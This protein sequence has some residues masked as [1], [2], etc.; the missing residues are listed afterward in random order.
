[1]IGTKNLSKMIINNRFVLVLLIFIISYIFFEALYSQTMLY[2]VGGFFGALLDIIGIENDYATSFI[3]WAIFLI[4]MIVLSFKLKNKFLWY[5]TLI[6]IWCL[7]YLVDVLFYELLPDITSKLLSN[8]HFGLSTFI[9]SI[10]LSFVYNIK[11][12]K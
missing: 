11:I 3:I 8:L 2:L 9:K 7:L 1:M 10:I 12:K 4:C 5:I 6:V